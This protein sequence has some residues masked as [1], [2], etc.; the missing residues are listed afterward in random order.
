MKIKHI[1]KSEFDRIEGSRRI[2][3]HDYPHQFAV[4]DLGKPLGYYGL[5]WR[6]SPIIQ[7]EIQ[8]SKDK[9]TLWVGVD[10]RLTAIDLQSGHMRMLMP[11]HNNLFQILPLDSRTIILTELEVLLFNNYDCS[12]QCIKALPEISADISVVGEDLAIRLMDDR[13]LILNLK[14]YKLKE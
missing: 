9:L 11:L 13:C 5:S 2:I 6:S 14:T 8:L 3:V 1:S 10:Q 7:P 4:L 12:I